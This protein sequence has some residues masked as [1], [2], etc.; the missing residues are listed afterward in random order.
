MKIGFAGLSHMG[1]HMA[2]DLHECGFSRA[3][4]NRSSEIGC[5]LATR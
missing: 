5:S 1:Q 2:R 3:V 4:W